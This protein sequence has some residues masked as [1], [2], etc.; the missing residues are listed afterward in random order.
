[1]LHARN[2]D[3]H[4]DN[5]LLSKHTCIFNFQKGGQTIFKTVGWP[6]FIGALSGTKPGCFSITL[7]AVLSQDTPEFDYPVSFL[8]RDVLEEAANFDEAKTALEQTTIASDCLLLLT[9]IH[10][11]EAVVIER[12]P[13]RFATRVGN[14]TLVVTNDYKVL[15]NGYTGEWNSLQS[16][17]C[18]R[19]DRANYLI[20]RELPKTKEDCINILRDGEIMMGITVQQ[21]VF[22]NHSGEILVVKV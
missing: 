14:E 15:E 4:T 1:M 18:N 7:N 20:M 12:T 8:L 19:L 3:W 13:K 16:T 21:M 22:D 11:H 5:D 6:G 2:L 10:E 9:G 17:S